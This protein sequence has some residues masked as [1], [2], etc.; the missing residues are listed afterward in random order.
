MSIFE[1]TNPHE[2]KELLA[3]ID[4]R[5][6]V[7]PDFQRDF[8]W[9][10]WMTQELVVSIANN[11]PAGSLL[12]VR[13][14]K[15]DFFA[16]RE[17]QGATR[18]GGYK[19]TFL[20]LDGQQR[21]TSLYQAF[22][23]VGEHRYYLDLK[24]LLG[25]SEFEEAIFHLRTTTKKVVE[26]ESEDIQAENLVVPL[27]VLKN[28]SGGF[29]K[30]TR[31]AA[32]R[33]PDADRIKLEDDLSEV[34]ERWIQTIDD[35]KFPVVTLAETTTADALCTIFETLNRTGVKLNVFEL[36]TARFW[37]KG[38][39]LRELW[40]AAKLENR[41]IEDFDVDPYY[42]LQAIAICSRKTA[43]CKKS[44]VL[45]LSAADINDWWPKIVEGMVHG[46]T[47]LRDDCKVMIPKWLPYGPMLVTI[48]AVLAKASTSN[49]PVAGANR[50]RIKRWFWCCVFGQKY[51]S[52]A[53][54]QT[55][56]D[57]GELLAWF[58]GGREPDS[59]TTFRFDPRA[60]IDVSP[61]Q[62]ALYR[63]TICLILGNGARDFHTQAVITANLILEAGIDDHHI[64]PD[65]FL[66]RNGVDVA[67]KRNCV[68]NR[69]LID[70]TTN[71][72]ISA[73]APSDYLK[74]IRDTEGFPLDAVLES[75]C[76]PTG[77]DSPFWTD[78]YEE[79]LNWRQ[80]RLW[81]EIKRVTGITEAT[82]LEAEGVCDRAN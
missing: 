47:I 82:D 26:Y 6:M 40:D 49:T 18:L 77:D 39:K 58:D 14:S 38:V 67:R 43:S 24:K 41:I 52:A 68:L 51:E 12:R 74:Q 27:S 42:L 10:P 25:G 44:D 70:A 9:D 48:A 69:T 46:L 31:M 34:E 57:Y 22:Y 54:S 78:D 20:V 23:G 30:W 62:R 36:L 35:Y 21:L 2:M 15:G 8:V 55:A 19:H 32:R 28:G 56:K 80:D 60:L 37:P 81:V 61:A 76:L 64:F 71:R 13:D 5:N 1:D 45:D 65:D 29:S 53:N 3:A 59:V 73:R 4:T 33:L 7:L 17:F 11:F 72:T 16:P 50:E 75:H 79:F 63:G 66:K